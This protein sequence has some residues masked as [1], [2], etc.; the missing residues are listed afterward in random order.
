MGRISFSQPRFEE[1]ILTF[2]NT[3]SH[4]ALFNVNGIFFVIP[5]KRKTMKTKVIFL[6]VLIGFVLAPIAHSFGQDLI[7]F[8][9][10]DKWGFSTVDKK[11]V[12]APKYEAVD[13]FS[14]GLA[15]VKSNGK[16][17][18]I[19]ADG[20]LIITNKYTV[21]KPFRRGYMPNSKGGSD[22]VIFAGASV[23]KDGYEICI[24]NKGSQ[25]PKCPAIPEN[26]VEENQ[27]PVGT[28][29]K[30]KQYTL[31]DAGGLFDKVLDDYSIG[32]RSTYYLATKNDKQG[33]FNSTFEI[34]VPF[35][36]DSIHINRAGSKPFLVVHKNGMIGLIHGEGTVGIQPEN[37]KL[38]PFNVDGTDYVIVQRK[39]RTVITD[40][41]N[42][43]VVERDFLSIQYDKRGGFIITNDD[44]TKGYV[45]KNR[46]VVLPKY[47]Q[48]ELLE[49]GK[50][51]HV[52]NDKGQAGFISSAGVEYFEE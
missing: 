40:L 19:N 8:R 41:M 16:W 25:M 42:N 3:Y 17:G 20:K 48:I 52:V 37:T 2:L 45:F 39:G 32:D 11:I 27:I 14:E 30:E 7:P 46:T 50:Y 10:G 38:T 24:N 49:N 13:W 51:I 5:S 6:Y 35:E 9:K 15:A 26:S 18:Y 33:V 28:V 21:A 43:K 4:F 44:L 31:P 12:I 1:H 29:V 22:T 23:A 47:S 34:I 36:Y